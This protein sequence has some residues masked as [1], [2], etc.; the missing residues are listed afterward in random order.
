MNENT[1]FIIRFYNVKNF[2]FKRTILSVNLMSNMI[3]FYMKYTSTYRTP[4]PSPIF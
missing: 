4:A 1:F 2:N 3:V